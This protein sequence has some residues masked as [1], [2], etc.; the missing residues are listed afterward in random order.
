MMLWNGF[1][2]LAASSCRGGWWDMP[3]GKGR[4]G[5]GSRGFKVMRDFFLT[6]DC[7][8]SLTTSFFFSPSLIMARGAA[9]T[10]LP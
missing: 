3:K 2:W 5:G 6:C 10:Y 8:A 7:T 9:H 1:G 4:G